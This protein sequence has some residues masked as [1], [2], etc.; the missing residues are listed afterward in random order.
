MLQQ[1]PMETYG[2][3]GQ[4]LSHSASPVLHRMLGDYAYTLFEKTPEELADFLTRGSFRGLNVTIPYK[5][6]V[7]PYLA[8]LSPRAAALGSVNTLLRR[9][10]GSLLGDNTDYPGFAYLLEAKGLNPMGKKV[11]VLGSGGASQTVQALLRD[12]GVSPIV[13]SRFGPENYQNLSRH[14]DADWI[15]NTTPVGMFPG[16]GQA[17]LSLAHFPALSLV[18][19]LIYNP[20]RTAL[21]LEAESRGI[22]ALNGLSMLAAQAFYSSRLWGLTEKT[23]AD[24]PALVNDLQDKQE[25]I[26]LIGMPGS[27]KS[28]RARQLGESLQRPVYD[29]DQIFTREEGISPEQFIREQGEAAFRSKESA[30]LARL[31]ALSGAVIATGGGAVTRPE[32]YPLLHQNGRIIWL[33]RPLSA[34]DISAKP[35]FHRPD[36]AVL[37]EER[38]ALYQS[39]ADEAWDCE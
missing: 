10:D 19:D 3:L 17:P 28:T 34:L 37:Y 4:S 39:W 33:R 26:I 20:L 38:K 31:G 12:R 9:T 14:Q 23:E 25:N 21:L 11:L 15:I 24:L 16:N 13:I 1:N 35:L 5:K 32:N 30:I 36:L 2:L 29:S 8:E 6:T 27:G 22:P 18:I 7:L